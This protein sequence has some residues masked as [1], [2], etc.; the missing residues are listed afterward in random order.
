MPVSRQTEIKNIEIS[1][2]SINQPC[3][4]ILSCICG[5]CHFNPNHKK[6]HSDI[7]AYTNL[8]LT[9]ANIIMETLKQARVNR[10]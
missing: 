8:S 2:I 7:K 5:M 1:T 10:G 3:P 4:V 9:E 6:W